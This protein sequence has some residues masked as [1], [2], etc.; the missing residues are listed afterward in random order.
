MDA[1]TFDLVQSP[2]RDVTAVL[3]GNADLWTSLSGYNQD[4]AI[5]VN[6][7]NTGDQLVAWKEAGG[8]AGTFSPNAAF[9]QAN[10]PMLAGH[11]Y[12]FKLK[13][14]TNRGVSGT[15]VFAGAGP[16]NGHF[17]P[18]SLTLQVSG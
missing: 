1:G 16:I 7:N 10:F 15:R 5:F 6:D 2:T 13:W 17:S 11:T 14:K 8:F 18:T 4:L 12:H 9:V 3:G